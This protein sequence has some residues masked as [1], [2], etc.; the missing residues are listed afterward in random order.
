MKVSVSLFICFGLTWTRAQT[1]E[2]PN[3]HEC[4]EDRFC[5]C[6]ADNLRHVPTVPANVL[7]LDLS[8]N[9][10]ESI[11]QK[12][13]AAYTELRTLKLQRNKLSTIHEKAFHSQSNL[14]Q[15]DLSFN[16][17][18]NISSLWFSKLRSLKHLN[19]LGNQY[20]TL[21][22]VALFQFLEN[23]ALRTLQFGNPFI[24][25]VKQNMLHKIKQL[26]ELTFVGGNLSAYENG[27]F[28]TA[29]PIRAVSVSLQ[30]LFQDD[31]VLVSKILRDVSH[32]ETSLTIR[33]VSLETKEPIQAFKK[34]REG[35]TSRLTIQ[36]ASTNDEGVTEILEVLDGS[37]L[38]YIGLEDIYLIGQGWWQKAHWTHYEN[39]NTILI[40]NLE[41]QGFFTFSSMLQL[42]FL[43]KHLTK[44]SVVNC[45][46][47]VIPCLTSFFLRK[48]EYMDLSQNLLSDITVKESL[49]SG[50]G[51][52]SDLNTLNV[53]HNS[54]KSLQLMSSLVSG[55][56]RLTSLDVSHNDFLKMPQMC[57]WPA[58]LRFLN[59][60]ATKLHRITPCLP[61]TLTVLDL[62]QNYLTAFHH[63]LP[64]LEELWL[65]GNR[66]VSLPEGGQFPSLQMLVIRSN[67]LSMFNKSELMAF[68]SLRVLEAGQN[69]FICSCDFVEFFQGHI[70]HLITLRDRHHSYVCDS[71]L[72]SRGRTVDSVQLSVFECHMILSVSVLC[73]VIVLVLIASGVT[74]YKLHVLWYLKMTM[75]WLKAKS[76]PAVR[77]GGATLRYDAFVSYSEQDAEWVEEILVPELESSNP[78]IALCL[79]KRDF[80]PGRWIVDNIIESIESSYRTLFVLSENFVTSEWCRYELDFSHFRIIDENNDSAVLILLEPI[81]KETIPKRFCKLRK[82][83]N[84]RTYLEWPQEEEKREEFWH[85]L[86]AALRREDY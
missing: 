44:I 25:E 8:F 81:T 35:C 2:R 66:F 51:I 45:T 67:A 38:S 58:S 86:R 31:P 19:I 11:S 20:T 9:E 21:G 17:L 5:N 27:S 34:I 61:V 29:L 39:L 42:G 37:P 76:K 69:N 80:L 14:E 49:C 46:V 47:F 22:S 85:N 70:D 41:I 24:K 1:S 28:Q 7:S 10:I 16:K 65:T 78:P 32:P 3:C 52:M 57:N 74:C 68:Q 62:S 33:D 63:R 73:S 75:A 59:L 6:S 60:S 26:D 77:T 23:P 53:S 64:N 15:L 83:M 82:I 50:T 18:E 40:R 56:H 13:L 4:D 55:L 48:V 72:T 54:L 12:D 79:H 43:L 84:S 36:N 71:P 30:G